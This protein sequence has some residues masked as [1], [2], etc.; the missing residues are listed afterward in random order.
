MRR[1][2]SERI[3]RMIDRRRRDIFR[4]QLLKHRRRLLEAFQRDESCT[5]A[6]TF[7]GDLADQAELESE[8]FVMSH[9]P[10]RETLLE[11]EQALEKL[12][13]GR[14]G[15]C[16]T[17]NRPIAFARLKAIPWA[18]QCRRCREREEFA[19]PRRFESPDITLWSVRETFE[20]QDDDAEPA[21]EVDL[22][23]GLSRILSKW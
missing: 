18:S 22:A 11:I 9:A 15:V 21:G 20:E 12:D 10:V 4:R 19:M 14:Y 17:C 8:V 3:T 7:S 23:P 6:E 16:E 1:D 2:S 13:S 5:D